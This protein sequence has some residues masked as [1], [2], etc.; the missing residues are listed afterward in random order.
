MCPGFQSP[1][2]VEFSRIS[3]P[4]GGQDD[5]GEALGEGGQWPCRCRSAS[6]PELI[7]VNT[8]GTAM[9]S[10]SAPGR[11][12]RAPQGSSGTAGVVRIVSSPGEIV[13]FRN[14]REVTDPP[15]GAHGSEP[16]C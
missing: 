15:T 13:T 1:C 2:A 7:S 16:T 8:G 12:P 5:R 3:G 6:W 10:P 14:V 9:G 11:L 4:G